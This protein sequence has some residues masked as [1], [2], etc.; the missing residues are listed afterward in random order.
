MVV[1]KCVRRPDFGPTILLKPP[2]RYL[3]LFVL[4]AP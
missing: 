4:R 3:Y 1:E 2:F